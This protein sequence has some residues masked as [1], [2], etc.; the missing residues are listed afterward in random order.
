MKVL[1][2]GGTGAIGRRLVPALLREG[3]EVAVIGRSEDELRRVTE[4]G[5][6]GYAY[7]V[8]SSASVERIMRSASPDVVIDEL[9]GLPASLRPRKLK[10]VYERNN[11]VRLEGGGNI[12][13]AARNIGVK[14]IVLQSA[15]YW[16][17]PSGSELKDEEQ[18]FFLDAPE[19]IG[20]AVRTMAAVEDR[21]LQSGLEVVI[22]RYG[23]FYG[24][25]TWYSADGDVGQQVRA[26]KFPLIGEGKGVFSFIHIDDAAKATVKAVSGPPGIY[27]V[28]DDSPVKS[29]VWLPAFAKA[30][31]AKSPR[32]VPVWLARMAAGSAMVTWMQSLKGA[33]NVR[34]RSRLNWRPRF[35]SFEEGFEHGLT[36]HP[37][38]KATSI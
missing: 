13:E 32:R 11:Q 17:D 14:R 3:Y 7:D 34:A 6:R 9:T 2:A 4:L 37:A 1:I 24:P 8:F 23:M 10:T 18:P 25:G 31:G 33:S 38:I 21:A 28:V 27:N 12:L 36:D 22:L 19:P 29:S 20:E 35:A 5:A 30:L 16:Y 26:R 15:A